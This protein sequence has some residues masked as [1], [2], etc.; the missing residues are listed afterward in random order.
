MWVGLYGGGGMGEYGD[1]FMYGDGF[2]NCYW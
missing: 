1:G 2:Y